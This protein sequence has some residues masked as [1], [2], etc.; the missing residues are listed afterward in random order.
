MITTTI[1][2]VGYGDFK[3]FNDNEMGWAIEMVYLTVITVIGLI[4]FAS[5]LNEVLNY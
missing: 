4:L 5:V 2:T 1:S 3:A